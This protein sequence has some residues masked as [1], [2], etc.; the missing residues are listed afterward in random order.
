[1]PFLFYR[2]D[3]DAAKRF[4]RS[5]QARCVIC[6]SRNNLVV[7]HDH[8]TD[9]IRGVLCNVCNTG[10]GIFHDSPRKL[11]R[12]IKY[13]ENSFKEAR[14]WEV[15]ECWLGTHLTKD[16]I[17]KR[18]ENWRESNIL[19]LSYGTLMYDDPESQEL[20]KEVMER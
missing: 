5:S 12:A 13:L 14:R 8:H 7:D 2:R 15:V 4:A 3:K 1:M 20:I 18:I 19:N 10:L 16:E 11:R 9:L 6:G 17:D